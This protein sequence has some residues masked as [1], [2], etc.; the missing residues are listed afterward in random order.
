MEKKYYFLKYKE[1]AGEVKDTA[2]EEVKA[3]VFVFGSVV[4]GDYCVGLSD[5]D[6]AVVSSDFKDREKKLKVYNKLFEKYFDSP[7]EFHL[8]TP[9]QWEFYLRFI[10][11][12]YLEV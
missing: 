10:G 1:I 8:L 3:R 4:R 12:D 6:I 2:N 11:R 5:I 7:I 9:E